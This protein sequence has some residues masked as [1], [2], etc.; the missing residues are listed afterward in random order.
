[1]IPNLLPLLRDCNRTW[2]IGRLLAF[3]VLVQLTLACAAS[4][5]AA[6]APSSIR[7]LEYDWSR[8]MW[9]VNGGMFFSGYSGLDDYLNAV[10]PAPNP[11]P[12]TADYRRKVDLLRA[13]AMKD[14]A[15]I[16]PTAKCH[17]CG[18]GCLPYGVPLV[19]TMP[20]PFKFQFSPGLVVILSKQGYRKIVTDIDGHPSAWEPSYDGHSIGHWEKDTLIVDTVGLSEKTMIEPGLPHSDQLHV[21]ERWRQTGPDELENR[22]EISDPKAFT[23]SWV[24]TKTYRRRVGIEP[25]EKPC[26]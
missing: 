23:H 21:I 12:L 13:G 6:A 16:D 4:S 5:G 10:G 14:R 11:A 26:M 20:E 2:S 22:I 3:A 24:V 18:G 8:D 7:T 15:S 25:Q 1:M 19:L 17:V 9:E